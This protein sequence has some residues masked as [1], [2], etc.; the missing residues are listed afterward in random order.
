MR[1]AFTDEQDM[2]RDAVRDL[3]ADACPPEAVRASWD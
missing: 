2:F 1:F 3:L